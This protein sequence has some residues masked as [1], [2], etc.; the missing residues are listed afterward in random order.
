MIWDVVLEVF[1]A[2][3]SNYYW[4]RYFV[5]FYPMDYVDKQVSEYELVLH[6]EYCKHGR[7]PDLPERQSHIKKYRCFFLLKNLLS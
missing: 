3:S 2:I 4:M 7:T 1:P 5:L 6:R